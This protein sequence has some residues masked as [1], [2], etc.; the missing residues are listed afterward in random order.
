MFSYAVVSTYQR[1][2]IQWTNDRVMSAQGTLVHW[3]EKGSLCVLIHREATI[4][5][6]AGTVNAGF[7]RKV[8]K[9]INVLNVYVAE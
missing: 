7:D 3:G 4:A 1:K 6:S 5:Q 8:R 2:D 9:H